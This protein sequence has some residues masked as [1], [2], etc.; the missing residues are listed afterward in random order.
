VELV[1]SREEVALSTVAFTNGVFDILHPGHVRLLRFARGLADKLVVAVN[2][3]ES[4]RRLKGPSRPINAASDRIEVLRAIRWVDEVVLFAEDTPEALLS[5]LRPDFLVKGPELRGRESEVPGASHAK[6]VVTPEWPVYHST[7]NIC[8]RIR[9]GSPYPLPVSARL[10]VRGQETDPAGYE[11]RFYEAPDGARPTLYCGG[12]RVAEAW[13]LE[14][15]HD[16]PEDPTGRS[17]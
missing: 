12:R 15:A 7:T 14:L 16:Q 11:L 17:A 10:A 4:A 8:A 1:P 6:T 13:S 9:A 5:V 3:D 2:T